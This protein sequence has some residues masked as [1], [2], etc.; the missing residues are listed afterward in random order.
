MEA[1]ERVAGLAREAGEGGAGTKE[2][3]AG[4]GPAGSAGCGCPDPRPPHALPPTWAAGPCGA[5]AAAPPLGVRSAPPPPARRAAAPPP[6]LRPRCPRPPAALRPARPALP[7]PARGR[8]VPKVTAPR[9]RAAPPREGRSPGTRTP[10]VPRG[11][12]GPGDARVGGSQAG[13]GLGARSPGADKRGQREGA[14]GRA[15]DEDRKDGG[16]GLV[17]LRTATRRVSHWEMTKSISES[18][19]QT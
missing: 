5:A 15:V 11:H 17:I 6:Q 19:K 10:T 9:A 12:L 18:T 1:L 8:R 16:R 4:G 13:E 2:G 14:L 3:R 7:G